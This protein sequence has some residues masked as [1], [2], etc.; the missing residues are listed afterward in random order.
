MNCKKTVTLNGAEQKVELRGQNCDIRNDGTGIVYVSCAPGVVPD[1]DGVLSVPGGQAVKYCGC[2]GT[3]YLLGTGKVQLCGNDYSSPVFKHAAAPSGVGGISGTALNIQNSAEFPLLG[4]N[5]YGKST[6][7]YASHGGT[8]LG[9]NLLDTQLAYDTLDSITFVLNTDKTITANGISSN[10]TPD[11]NRIGVVKLKAG[12]SYLISGCP[13]GGSDQSY[14]LDLRLNDIGYTYLNIADYG[15][16]A[17]YTPIQDE[18]VQMCIRWAAG[19]NFEN[20]TFKPMLRLA[21]ETD[22]TYEPYYSAPNPECPVPIVSVG[23]DGE[24]KLQ[25]CGKNLISSTFYRSPINGLT[26]MPNDDNTV[27]IN[28]VSTDGVYVEV[29]VQLPRFD[30]YILTGCPAGGTIDSYMLSTIVNG[31]Y[32]YDYG[33]GVVI[34]KGTRLKIILAI[35]GGV[36]CDNLLFKPMLRFAS[37]T[38]DTYEPYTGS[39]A[40]ITSVLPLCSTENVRDELIYKAG[41]AGKVVK[42]CYVFSAFSLTGTLEKCYVYKAN[43]PNTVVGKALGTGRSMCNVVSTYSYGQGDYA[44]FYLADNAALVYVPIDAGVDPVSIRV[45]AELETPEEINLTAEEVAQLEQFYSYNGV[46]NIFNDEGAEMRV[47]YCN[48]PLISEYYLPIVKG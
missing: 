11:I 19:V 1:A 42:R 46:T 24:V 44:H 9:K 48:S 15:S 21:S 13:T 31:E 12:V 29:M 41:G 43:A 36:V 8:P 30:K 5:L 17:L 18:E 28:G 38:D 2:H 26:F 20:I 7:G 25:C 33:S 32:V 39:T 23:D 22:N 10:T 40:S 47:K 45:L 27:L 3:V 34:E 6:Q 14:R 35:R 16:G 37:D 4:L